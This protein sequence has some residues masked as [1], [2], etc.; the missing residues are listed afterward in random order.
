MFSAARAALL[1]KNALRNAKTIRKMP[2]S[3]PPCLVTRQESYCKGVHSA[4]NVSP[5]ESKW[6]EFSGGTTGTLHLSP[7]SPPGPAG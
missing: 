7:V 1:A 5:L 2:I 3:K 6:T 4:R